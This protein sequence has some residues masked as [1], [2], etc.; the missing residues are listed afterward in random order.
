M[1]ET[2]GTAAQVRT[3]KP[4][5]GKAAA[6]GADRKALD[7]SRLRLIRLVRRHLDE[8]EGLT[9]GDDEVFD[10]NTQRAIS[11]YACACED[12]LTAVVL[13]RDSNPGGIDTPLVAAYG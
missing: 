11:H 3:R 6:K 8:L 7:R 5:R 13:I 1:N 9:D 2:N 4:A 12:T 10:T